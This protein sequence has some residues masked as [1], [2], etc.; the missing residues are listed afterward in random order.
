MTGRATDKSA[1]AI[2]E[3]LDLAAA[4]NPEMDFIHAKNVLDGDPYCEFEV[5]P[6]R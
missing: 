1:E 5:R 4:Y 2:E 6:K 3:L